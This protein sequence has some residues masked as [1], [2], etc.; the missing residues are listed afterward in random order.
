MVPV[1]QHIGN[2][3]RRVLVGQFEGLWAEPLNLDDRDSAVRQDPAQSDIRLVLIECRHS[4]ATRY[5]LCDW[6]RVRPGQASEPRPGFP[7]QG[8]LSS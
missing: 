3:S 1:E 8:L 5:R 6:P 2:L 7:S 4:R